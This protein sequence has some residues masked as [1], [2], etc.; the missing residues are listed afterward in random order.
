M[1]DDK[2]M[3]VKRVEIKSAPV[4]DPIKRAIVN[5]IY[6]ALSKL[7]A[8]NELLAIVGSWGDTMDDDRTLDH[9]R[10]FNRNGTVF[11]EVICKAD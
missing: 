5:E 7:Q 1:S 9:L 6:F 11:S 3:L 2:V 10:A 8:P 4:D